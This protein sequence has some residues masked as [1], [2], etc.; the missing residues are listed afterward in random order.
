MS[1]ALPQEQRERLEELL[2]DA[3]LVGLSASEQEELETLLARHPDIDAASFDCTVAELDLWLAGEDPAPLPAHL[4]DKL[5]KA[6]QARHATPR[7]EKPSG[8]RSRRHRSGLSGWMVAAVCLLV[9]IVIWFQRPPS[10]ED[11]IQSPSLAEQRR[12]LL[13]SA[14]DPLVAGW[15]AGPTAPAGASVKGNVVWS[16]AKQ[17]GFM[18]FRGLPVNNPREEQYQLW[19]FDAERDKRYPVDGGV[20]NVESKTG[21]VIVAI[22][23][24]LPVFEPTL[25]AI[26]VEP[27]GGVVVSDRS[28]LVRLA[29]VETD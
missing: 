3:A 27:P 17:T 12:E 7:V 8:K 25:F 10:P 28:R 9:A 13:E 21:E 22:N 29:K 2:A 1:D 15:Q 20:F 23:A 14:P 5:L 6:A 16:D 4:H 19:I 11:P 24:K 18:T 26:T